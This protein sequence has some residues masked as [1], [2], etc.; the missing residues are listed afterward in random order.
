[1]DLLLRVSQTGDWSSWIRFF[2]QGVK[3]C[4]EESIDQAEGLLQL[5]ERYRGQ[6]QSARSSALLQKLIDGLF[7]SP[8]LTIG[9]AAK[10]L[11]V[12][13]AAAAYNVRKL[14]DAGILREVTGRKRDQI[15]VAPEIIAFMRDAEAEARRTPGVEA[16]HTLV[17]P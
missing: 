9:H 4:S 1:M 12:T 13:H 3:E 7:Q 5:R 2:L 14:M 17:E 8:S 15:F 6:F 16:E 11:E 10:L